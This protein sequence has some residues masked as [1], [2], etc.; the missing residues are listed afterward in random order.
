M[1]SALKQVANAA[2]NAV[3]G[4][5]TGHGESTWTFRNSTFPFGILQRS[6]SDSSSLLVPRCLLYADE[7][8]DWSRPRVAI[9][10]SISILL[11]LIDARLLMVL[12]RNVSQVQFFNI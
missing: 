7:R 1:I 11:G 2:T 3:T 4:N 12:K 5:V 10:I 9:S 6:V 8:H